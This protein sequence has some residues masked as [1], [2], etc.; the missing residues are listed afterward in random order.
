MMTRPRANV[1]YL[2]R[3]RWTAEDAREVLA[4][5]VR[6]GLSVSAFAEQVG[7]DPQRLYVWRR[8][9]SAEDGASPSFVELT[10]TAGER[11]EV[12]L[13]SGHVVR[14]PDGFEPESLKRLL[15]V[16]EPT[17]SC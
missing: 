16:L 8:R 11:I 9:F 12:V 3:A 10:A 1:T 4:A 15:E 7:L 2:T 5:Q 13:R 14:V 6:S 17:D